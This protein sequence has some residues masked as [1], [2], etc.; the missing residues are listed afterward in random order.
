[1]ASEPRKTLPHSLIV[2]RQLVLYLADGTLCSG[3]WLGEQLGVSR[4]A[5][6]KHLDQLQQDGLELY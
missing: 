2:Q 3:Q 4:T 5:V 6:A 1:M